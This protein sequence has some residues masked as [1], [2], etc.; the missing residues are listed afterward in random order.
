[1][2][3]Q[4]KPAL[5]GQYAIVHVDGSCNPNPGPGG[6]AWSASLPDGSI[7][8]YQRHDPDTNN[9]IQE[10]VALLSFLKWL[11][12][13]QHAAVHMDS[14]FVVKGSNEWLQ[15]W[16]AKGWRNS[17]GKPVKNVELWKQISSL[18]E[19]R[20]VRIE[21]VRGHSG[22]LMNEKADALAKQAARDWSLT[23]GKIRINGID[24]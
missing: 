6:H 1:M 24:Q 13:D 20:K 7:V 21:W 3:T 22:N 12:P 5:A 19:N 16:E 18:L 9:A 4:E 11:H 23:D 10:M 2:N 17:G 15:G 8:E 14:Q